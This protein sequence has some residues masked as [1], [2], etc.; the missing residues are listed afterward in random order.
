MLLT[1]ESGKMNKAL[2]S[3]C[4]VFPIR[5]VT[6]RENV[7]LMKRVLHSEGA[8]ELPDE[9]LTQISKMVQG[10][11][12][13][14]LSALESVIHYTEGGHFENI[15]EVISAVEEDVLQAAP[16]RLIQEYVYFVLSGRV[17]AA[18]TKIRSAGSLEFFMQLAIASIKQILLHKINPD[19]ADPNYA[20]VAKSIK[21]KTASITAVLRKFVDTQ[22]QLKGYLVEAK[23]LVDLVTIEACEI[24]KHGNRIEK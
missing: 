14:V 3:R 24:V 22:E 7:K 9:L 13:D 5:Q 20:I 4:I 11:P 12:R 8:E 21:C 2:K 23:D 6:H 19:L 16:Y 10:H 1:T 17:A 18:L 15:E